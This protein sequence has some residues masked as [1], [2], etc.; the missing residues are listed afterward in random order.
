MGYGIRVANLDGAVGGDGAEE[1]PD[2]ALGLVGPPD[3]G[4][5][6]AEEDNRVDPR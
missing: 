5:A 2:D 1:G 3:V 6:D 4:V